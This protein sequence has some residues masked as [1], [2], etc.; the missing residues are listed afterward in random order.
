MPP[1]TMRLKL[2]HELIVCFNDR[3]TSA[4]GCL[5]L[6]MAE[7]LTYLITASRS[8]K[9]VSMLSDI[10]FEIELFRRKA[11]VE[12]SLRVEEELIAV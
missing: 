10:W 4:M 6:D 12:P 7:C 3:Y 8:W 2:G 11:F 9:G 5:E 1:A